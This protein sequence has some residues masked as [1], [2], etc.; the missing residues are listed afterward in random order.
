MSNEK[1]ICE[2]C[3]DVRCA[4]LGGPLLPGIN[5]DCHEPNKDLIIEEKDKE[6][7]NL[8][9]EVSKLKGILTKFNI[10][11]KEEGER[12]NPNTKKMSCSGCD[13]MDLGINYCFAVYPRQKIYDTDIK[14]EC[15]LCEPINLKRGIIMEND[16]EYEK[17]REK[18]E[19]ML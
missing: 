6:I 4:M 12:Y 18:Y 11:F 17:L 19:G 14:K 3:D 10:S 8:K 1:R 2:S 9:I 7:E 16:K 15:P 5:C 13:F